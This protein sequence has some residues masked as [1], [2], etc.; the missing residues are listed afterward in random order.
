MGFL[1][2]TLYVPNTIEQE[3]VD[4]FLRSIMIAYIDHLLDI[5]SEYQRPERGRVG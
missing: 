4:M 2:S 5:G 3:V 1:A